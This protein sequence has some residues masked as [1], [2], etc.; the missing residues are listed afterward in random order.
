MTVVCRERTREESMYANRCM[1]IYA[2]TIYNQRI[3][4]PMFLGRIPFG[5][6][7][8][9]PRETGKHYTE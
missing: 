2:A 5:V 6:E 3:A 4:C 7:T 9:K 8:L 1:S